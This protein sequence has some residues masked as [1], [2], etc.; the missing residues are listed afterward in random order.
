MMRD[1]RV[2][3]TTDDRRPSGQPRRTGYVGVWEI[4]D[5]QLIPNYANGRHHLRFRFVRRLDE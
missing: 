5:F 4:D 2:I 3:E 1:R